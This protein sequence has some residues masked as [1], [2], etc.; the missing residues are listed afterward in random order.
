MNKDTTMRLGVLGGGAWGT[1]LACVLAAKGAPITL[2]AHEQETV[3]AINQTHENKLFL[4]GIELPPHITATTTLSD[5]AVCDGVLMV[6]PAQFARGI[7]AAMRDAFADEKA[8][9]L[10]SKGVER[11]SLK[12]MSEVAGTFFPPE[13]IAVLSGPS[14]AADVARGLPTAVTLACADKALGEKLVGAIGYKHFRPYLS[15]DIIGA[16]IGGAVKNVLAIACGI[17]EGCHLGESARAA[18]IA[19]GF[20]EMRQ[21]G[22]AM[23]AQMHTMAGLSGLGDLVLTASSKN[24]RNY[25]LGFALGEGKTM[26]EIMGARRSVSEGAFSAQAVQHL[27]EKYNLD[28]PI[29]AA[30]A[31]IIDGE[32][33]IDEAISGLLARPFIRED[34][35]ALG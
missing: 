34:G 14:F 9:V 20:S 31:H 27:A 24:S 26:A 17:V 35:T 25:S 28:L 13:K 18:I 3:Q 33:N 7:M 23:G 19:R 30:V 4:P 6:V 32:K 2:W 12:L 1:A 5:M 8:I 21:L 29:C 22:H 11:T 15:D 10:C 16:E